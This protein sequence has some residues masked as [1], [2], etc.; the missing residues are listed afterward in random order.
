MLGPRFARGPKSKPQKLALYE[1]FIHK[2]LYHAGGNSGMRIIFGGAHISQ[3]CNAY[4]SP[5]VVWDPLS[6][7]NL[8]G[9][10]LSG[11]LW[12]V[13]CISGYVVEWA[14]CPKVARIFGCFANS[15]INLFLFDQSG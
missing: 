10:F 1:N 8:L 12:V 15:G 14:R 13:L 2:R 5:K 6:N 4:F 11:C 3:M 7:R 9:D